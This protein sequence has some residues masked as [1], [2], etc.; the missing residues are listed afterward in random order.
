MLRKPKD[1]FAKLFPLISTKLLSP[2]DMAFERIFVITFPINLISE[3][4]II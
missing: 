3:L 1:E 2:V 4:E